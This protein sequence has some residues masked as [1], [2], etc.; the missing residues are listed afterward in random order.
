MTAKEFFQKVCQMREAQKAYFK[1]RRK[2]DLERSRE[3]EILIDREIERVKKIMP[4]S[5]PQKPPT[6]GDLFNQ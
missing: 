4:D 6:T 1:N 3:L 2:T 5:I